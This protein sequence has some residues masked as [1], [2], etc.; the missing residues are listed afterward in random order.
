MLG[1][2]RLYATSYGLD[3]RGSFPDRT[4][5]WSPLGP[6]RFWGPP[7]LLP[8]GHRG[9]FR[10]GV[11]QPVCEGDRSQDLVPKSSTAELY[12][13]SPIRFHGVRDNFTFIL[14]MYML[15]NNY[16]LFTVVALHDCFTNCY[17]Q[18][19]SWTFKK[20]GYDPLANRPEAPRKGNNTTENL[21]VSLVIFPCVSHSKWSMEAALSSRKTQFV[22]TNV[23][24]AVVWQP[25]VERGVQWLYTT[26]DV[27]YFHLWSLRI[28]SSFQTLTLNYA[29]R[30]ISRVEAD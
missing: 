13:E 4:E 6:D 28:T 14:W 25:L 18:R 17:E 26:D 10:Q 5:D 21:A 22:S 30:E 1:L 23:F 15:L 24:V 3:G 16:L 2:F 7:S 19:N 11:K 9:F 8:N 29:S 12:L 27:I 20:A